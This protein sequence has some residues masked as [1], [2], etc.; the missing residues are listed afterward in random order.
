MF[1]SYKHIY[2]LKIILVILILVILWQALSQ[3]AKYMTERNGHQINNHDNFLEYRQ[4]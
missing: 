3:F 2:T 4:P 1:I